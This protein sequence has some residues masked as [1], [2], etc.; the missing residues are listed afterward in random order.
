MRRA[1]VQ[2]SVPEQRSAAPESAILYRQADCGSVRTSC[3]S[4]GACKYLAS[5]T[6]RDANNVRDVYAVDVTFKLVLRTK[7]SACAWS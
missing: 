5:D 4:A 1:P 3:R 6:M 7:S 2:C